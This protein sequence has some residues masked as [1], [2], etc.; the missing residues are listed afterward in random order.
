MKPCLQ[1][2]GIIALILIWGCSG[3]SGQS[4]AASSSDD[5]WISAMQEV[6]ATG[7]SKG[8]NSGSVTQ[9]GDS[10]TYSM[11]FLAGMKYGKPTG[12]EWQSLRD[13]VDGDLINS[14][15][16]TA[17][18]NYSGWTSVDA[19]A[20]VDGVLAAH[21]SELAVIMLGTNDVKNDVAIAIYE[22]KLRAIV[23]ACLTAGTI[24]IITTIPPTNVKPLSTVQ[25]FNDVVKTIA[26]EKKLPLIDYYDAILT[27]QPGTAWDG[28]LISDDGVHPSNPDGSDLWDFS[29]A[30]LKINGYALRN[31]VT[32]TTMQEVVEQVL[33]VP[34]GSG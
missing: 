34:T 22:T 14:R 32:C 31:Y 25:A 3:G 19:A 30:N 15:K 21:D 27:R 20:A 24:P 23:D 29:T 33:S 6:H 28:T 8:V 16:G 4:Q 17:H 2:T 13:H 7:L 5:D 9:I 12:S 26:A 18:A 11:A 1:L 10:I